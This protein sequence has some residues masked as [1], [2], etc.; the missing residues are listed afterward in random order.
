MSLRNFIP[1][2]AKVN[3]WQM[4]AIKQD[5][6]TEGNTK[7]NYTCNLL[8]IHKDKFNLNKKH[9]FTRVGAI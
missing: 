9:T 8:K 7:K 2:T 3:T 4:N 5:I 6:F 1:H